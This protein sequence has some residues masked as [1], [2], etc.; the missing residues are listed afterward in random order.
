MR[1]TLQAC[2]INENIWEL[3]KVTGIV[4]WT[5]GNSLGPPANTFHDVEN[6]C[7]SWNNISSW[8]LPCNASTLPQILKI[9]ENWL[10]QPGLTFRP[11][12]MTLALSETLPMMLKTTMT[13]KTFDITLQTKQ[14]CI[15][16]ET[17]QEPAWA[18][19]V[20]IWTLGMASVYMWTL[21]IMYGTITTVTTIHFHEYYIANKAD[22]HN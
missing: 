20:D 10:K 5:I 8:I 15:I 12:G 21:P 13:V 2:I 17:I 3:A 11:S 9:F 14:I 16:I 4:I 1:I 22:L 6:N 19:G 18:T 7:D